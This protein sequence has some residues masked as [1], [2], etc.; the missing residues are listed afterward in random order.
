[1]ICTVCGIL[2]PQDS[3]LEPALL[4]GSRWEG[5]DE[6]WCNVPPSGSPESPHMLVYIDSTDPA[7]TG[8]WPSAAQSTFTHKPHLQL[9]IRMNVLVKIWLWKLSDS[10][11]RVYN[12]VSDAASKNTLQYFSISELWINSVKQIQGKHTVNGLQHFAISPIS[13][14]K[15]RKKFDFG[16]FWTQKS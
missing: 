8:D 14:S 10:T 12:C 2:A 9:I 6:R 11:Y 13:S 3:P 15:T 7:L 4:L 5:A 16:S 1:M